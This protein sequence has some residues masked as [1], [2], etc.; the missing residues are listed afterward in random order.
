[1]VYL[2][3]VIREALNDFSPKRRKVVRDRFGLNQSGK[4]RTLQDIGDDLGLTRE[5][6]R[7]IEGAARA[8]LAE[9]F[10][11]LVPELLAEAYLFL[12]GTGGVRRDDYFITDLERAV[13]VEHTHQM[14]NKLR[15]ILVTAE[16]APYFHEGDRDVLPFWYADEERRTRVLRTVKNIVSFFEKEGPEAILAKQ[17][18]FK[19][20]DTF[21]LAR[22]ATL[23]PRIAVSPFG[24]IGLEE[25]AEINPRFVRD[26]AY[27]VL[28]KSPEPL[29][30]RQIARLI[31]DAGLSRRRAHPQTV[32]NELIKDER[33]MLVGRGMYGLEEHGFE[34]G[35]VREVIARILK[36]KGPLNAVGVVA[37]VQRR[38]FSKENTILL[39]LQNRQFFERFAEGMY[40]LRGAR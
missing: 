18:H 39:N 23:S 4:R 16:G 21:E 24:D 19:A 33:F 28:K 1:M 37:E 7:Q 27:L 13:Q 34:G 14:G 6:V 17:P 9:R 5:R 35:T 15:F 25:W 32:H 26:K 2:D 8:V 40:R 30:F 31:T 10:A 3:A 29:H 12:D 36:E 22:A 11:A 20:F 38:K